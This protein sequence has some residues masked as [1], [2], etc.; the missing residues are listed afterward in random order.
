MYEGQATQSILRCIE[1][2][3]PKSWKSAM[4]VT[5]VCVV[6]AHVFL[7]GIPNARNLRIKR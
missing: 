4:H 5:N 7:P 6:L 3:R 1:I 2:A